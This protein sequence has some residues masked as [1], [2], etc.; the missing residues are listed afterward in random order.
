[1]VAADMQIT[2]FVPANELCQPSAVT[3]VTGDW[4]LTLHTDYEEC[5]RGDYEECARGKGKI[6]Q[7][8]RTNN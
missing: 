6:V 5:A 7:S 2:R 1:M 8:F 4:F 3:R